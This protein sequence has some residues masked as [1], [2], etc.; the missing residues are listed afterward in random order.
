[1]TGKSLPPLNSAY[2]LDK[3]ADASPKRPR[4]MATLTIT[5]AAHR[6]YVA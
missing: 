4:P 2:A 1:L 5:E 3:D 6:C